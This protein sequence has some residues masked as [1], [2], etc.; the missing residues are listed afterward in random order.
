M[1]GGDSKLRAQ[2]NK[3]VDTILKQ[4]GQEPRIIMVDHGQL[5]INDV[6]VQRDKNE[7][8][9]ALAALK[10]RFIAQNPNGPWV[11]I[12]PVIINLTNRRWPV[13]L[14][15]EEDVVDEDGET[16]KC[17]KVHV[18]IAMGRHARFM[19]PMGRDQ[20]MDIAVN[21]EKKRRK[22]MVTA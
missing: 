11:E 6:P 5:Y 19:L 2:L 8:R 12:G 10:D 14:P 16:T 15:L 9:V 21:I 3:V 17:T 7:Q 13:V 20:L 4:L 18:R 1:R 22:L